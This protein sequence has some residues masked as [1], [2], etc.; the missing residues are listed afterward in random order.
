M[1][2][3]E[4]KR[5]TLLEALKNTPDNPK[6]LVQL[7]DVEFKLGC[8]LEALDKYKKAAILGYHGIENKLNIVKCFFH[9]N[10]FKEAM[11]AAEQIIDTGD[12]NAEFYSII[13]KIAISEEKFDLAEEFYGYSV[14]M[15]DS[16]ADSEIEHL[17]KYKGQK[18]PHQE[19]RSPVDLDDQY[20]ELDL[21]ENDLED[22]SHF[23][24]IHACS[25]FDCIDGLADLKELLKFKVIQQD[26]NPQLFKQFNQRKG[27]S[28]LLFG[29]DGCGK[30]KVAKSLSFDSGR[31]LYSIETFEFGQYKSH[32]TRRILDELYQNAGF[33]ENCL[34]LFNNLKDLF[35]NRKK[36]D[37][38]EVAQ[39]FHSCIKQAKTNQPNIYTI[40]T[41]ICP[42]ELDVCNFQFDKLYFVPPPMLV[43]RKAY[44]KN[45]L[46]ALPTVSKLNLKKIAEQTIGFTYHDLK[47]LVDKAAEQCLQESLQASGEI[48]QITGKTLLNIAKTMTASSEEW[49]RLA[50][51]HGQF[52]NNKEMLKDV[53]HYLENRD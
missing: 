10:K 9:L 5:S 49:L 25:G 26:L 45:E 21:L 30:E 53:F 7:A 1:N 47:E 20:D 48:K 13:C 36:D 32:E 35:G 22:K 50:T 33:S 46:K 37:C 23:R 28:I 18:N 27:G 38:L 39:H 12:G 41:S 44:L 6:L 11:V 3:D 4:N 16:F 29:P 15:D 8:V 42:W 51:I 17:L 19:R 14:D 52:G 43:G 24:E 34:L 40:V 2:L 31:P